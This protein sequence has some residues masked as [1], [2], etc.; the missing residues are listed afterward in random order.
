[1]E[2][3]TAK[4]PHSREAPDYGHLLAA[5]HA[6]LAALFERLLAAFQADAREDAARLWTAFDEGLRSHL[7]LEEEHL[8]PRFARVDP[9]EA[10]A[11][12][13]EHHH[14]RD[15]LLRM[16]IGV[17]LHL[18][19]DEQVEQFIRELNAHA[20]REDA[21]MYRWTQTELGDPTLRELLRRWFAARHREDTPS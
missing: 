11:L 13:T 6:W 17:D 19:R 9:D 14:I 2:N 7:A 20:R 1:M 8:L 3:L 15:K 12:L 4:P 18:T 10:Q 16:G 5:D 21:L